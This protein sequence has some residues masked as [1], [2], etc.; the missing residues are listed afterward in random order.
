MKKLLLIILTFLAAVNISMAGS[1]DVREALGQLDAYIKNSSRYVSEKNAKISQIQEELSKKGSQDFELN[2]ALFDEYKSFKF[3]SAY[4]YAKNTLDLAQKSGNKDELVRARC[5]KAFCYLSSGLFLEAFY[6]MSL[7]DPQDVSPTLKDKY[8]ALYNRLYYD[9]SEYNN[10]QDWSIEY[11]RI[12]DQYADSV[13]FVVPIDSHKHLFMEAI[14]SLRNGKNEESIVL[15]KKILS[16]FEIDEHYKAIINSSIGGAYRALGQ[17][18]SAIV[19]L[20]KAA[21]NDIISSTKETTALYRL[22]EIMYD[23]EEYKK[24]DEYIHIALADAEIYDARHRKLSINPLIPH[25]EEARFEAVRRQ[26]NYLTVIVILCFGI[27][28]LLVMAYITFDRHRKTIEQRNRQLQEAN[29]IKEE[30]IGN[31]FFLNSEYITDLEQLFETINRKLSDNQ[32]DD[33]KN[34]C[35]QSAVNKKRELMYK[36]FDKCFL[37]IFPSFVREYAKLFPAGYIDESADTLT[38]EMRIF[39]LMR[40]GITDAEKISKFLN[41]SVHTVYTYKTRAKNKAIVDNDEFENR[42]KSFEIG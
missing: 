29:S 10:A 32:Y 38:S 39:A 12:G 1:S 16:D 36:S 13:M 21:I 22:A 15:Y 5:S 41:Y 6:E 2:Y 23:R 11:S 34:L 14:K 3:D 30:Y 8:F 40:L 24:A 28:G 20:A 9:A 33:L 4:F 26:R 31:T 35:K 7:I 37:K 19:Y 17:T 42:I 18:D 25:I 27:I